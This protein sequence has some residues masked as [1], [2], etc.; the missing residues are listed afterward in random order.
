MRVVTRDFLNDNEFKSYPIDI[1][2][3]YEP[4]YSTD[5]VSSINC[6]LTD[7]S[8]T[9]PESAAAC[10]FIANISITRSLISMTI[11]GSKS[12][13]FS[14]NAPDADDYSLEYSMLGSYV[15]AT[16]E[17]RRQTN[18]NGVTVAISPKIPGVGGWITFGSG[19]SKEGVWIFQG[20]SSSMISDFC[21][22][23]YSYGGVT[24]IGRLGYDTVLD[25]RVEMTGQNGI[26]IQ[27]DSDKNEIIIRF[28]GT[29][30]EIK[31]SLRQY[32]GACG[33][34][35]ESETCSFS[36]IKTING[37]RPEGLNSEI[38]LVLDRPLYAT[39]TNQQ[40][41]RENFKISSDIP[42]ESFCKGR[43]S[44]PES[45]ASSQSLT[46][47]LKQAFNET[48]SQ[49]V[50]DPSI[51]LVFEVH[52]T[53]AHVFTIFN[54]SHQ[55]PLNAGQAIFKSNGS[56]NVLGESL[57]ELVIDMALGE[58][59][60]YGGSGVSMT[61]FG[62]LLNNLRAFKEI[63]YQGITYQVYIGIATV[64]D[65]QEVYAVDVIISA[66]DSFEEAGK[67]VRIAHSRYVHSNNP[68]YSLEL[69]GTGNSWILSKNG[70][71]LGAGTLDD[72]GFDSKVQSYVRT[73][74]ESAIRSLAIRKAA[75]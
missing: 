68:E 53:G 58:W 30:N 43:I 37:I 34:R 35:P 63:T 19:A 1:R 61:L 21:I 71:L 67:Y 66:P 40:T 75:E 22:T 14:D 44:I 42:L 7:M 11:M 60:M 73:N 70:M 36:P 33:G 9:I 64:Y 45:C 25:G 52:S 12:H 2:A 47:I 20:P 49:I 15:V 31:Q 69:R 29:S 54:Y 72:Q 6:L 5:K 38:V 28:S 27:P 48:T 16:V 46:N 55:N 74:G 32:S 51:K 8:I 3:T 65:L 24:T 39:I 59:Q 41:E 57:N 4:Y 10:I 62:S 56:V 18:M 17:T 26:E 13:P 50:P 23:K